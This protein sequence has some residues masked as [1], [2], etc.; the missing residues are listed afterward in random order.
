[1]S[2]AGHAA[3]A[4]DGCLLQGGKI[5]IEEDVPM[6]KVRHKVDTADL[7]MTRQVRDEERDSDCAA[8][9]GCSGLVEMFLQSCT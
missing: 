6:M 5:A 7:S 8:Q 3:A 4:A 9:T 1:M 2:R